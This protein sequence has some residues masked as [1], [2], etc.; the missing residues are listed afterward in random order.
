MIFIPADVSLNLSLVF[1][2]LHFQGLKILPMV[3]SFPFLLKGGVWEPAVGPSE[4]AIEALSSPSTVE[5]KVKSE[6]SC[7][8]SLTQHHLFLPALF[9]V[10]IP[11]L[12]EIS[13]KAYFAHLPAGRALL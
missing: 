13:H 2:F 10:S 9:K 7:N 1:F 6:K 5:R 8:K 4:F 11:T 12:T 3:E